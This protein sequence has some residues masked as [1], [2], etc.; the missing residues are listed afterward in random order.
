MPSVTT[1]A[2]Y[3]DR[4][5]YFELSIIGH[6]PA[7]RSGIL[8]SYS[9][10]V[11][12][13]SS[14]QPAGNYEVSFGIA[15]DKGCRSETAIV[16]KSKKPCFDNIQGTK[17]SIEHRIQLTNSEPI[18]QRYIS[19]NTKRHQ[20]MNEEV[21]RIL[22]EGIFLFLQRLQNHFAKSDYSTRRRNL[23]FWRKRCLVHLIVIYVLKIWFWKAWSERETTVLP[24]R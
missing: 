21:D 20:V 3:G 2:R 9:I 7:G 10:G 22:E 1:E 5:G 14:M 16:F 11:S 4:Y 8:W 23:K 17:T 15:T 24:A 6:R 19:Q 18:K 12:L 13:S